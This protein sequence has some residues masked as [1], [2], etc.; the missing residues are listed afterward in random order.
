MVMPRHFHNVTQ[1]LVGQR[2]GRVGISVPSRASSTREAASFF[3]TSCPELKNPCARPSTHSGGMD[4]V[5]RITFAL[6]GTPFAV[7]RNSM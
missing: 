4:Y 2:R 7:I 6:E 5:M 3:H 1:G